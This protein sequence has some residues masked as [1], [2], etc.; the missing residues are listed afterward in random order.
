M[1]HSLFSLGHL[2]IQRKAIKMDN[3]Y[4]EDLFRGIGVIIDDEIKDNDSEAYKMACDFREHGVPI[5]EFDSIP[6]ET[7]IDS[8]QNISFA[9]LDWEFKSKP[10]EFD[11]EIDLGVSV[12]SSLKEEQRQSILSFL[13]DLLSK[14]FIPV[15][16]I[17]GQDFEDV[18]AELIDKKVYSEDKPT[19]IMLQSKESISGYND[20]IREVHTWLENTPSALALK[21][22]EKE[23]VRTKN[24]MF[25]ELYKASPN[26]VNVLLKS[27]RNDSGNKD[28]T[29]NHEFNEFLNNSFVNRMSDGPYSQIKNIRKDG[30][31]QEEIRRIL[32]GE[33]YI[34]YNSDDLPEIALVGDLYKSKVGEEYY[35]NI[36]AQCNTIRNDNPV[37][38][39]I[40]GKEMDISLISR[41]FSISL[42]KRMR[43]NVIMVNQTP[44][45]VDSLLHASENDKTR[46]NQCVQ[47]MNKNVVFQRG[48]IIEKKTEAIVA[49][50]ANK[51]LI[52]FQFDAFEAIKKSNLEERA[53]RIGRLLPPYITKIQSRFASYM[54]REGVMALPD[55]L[56]KL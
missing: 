5:V 42:R 13:E 22:W 43:E 32:Q 10:F 25:L 47:S 48:E 41:P 1:Q 17:T 14:T 11:Q 26:W 38:Y 6:D 46:F 37:L 30:K 29:V 36:R 54:V 31:N 24:K 9:V 28:R 55:E 40:P 33:R 21:I 27:M 53:V 51:Y 34:E 52:R 45:P 56:F 39:L 18:K 15:F 2:I 12:G 44:F 3:K 19:R 16:I 4:V 50:I 8:L 35:L 23:A 49:C 7:I 20:L